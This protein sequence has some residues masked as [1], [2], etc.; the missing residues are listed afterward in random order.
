MR[1]DP[2][3]LEADHEDARPLR[4][5][6]F[7][8]FAYVLLLLVGA[9]GALYGAFRLTQ[10]WV[11]RR[12]LEAARELA[13]GRDPRRAQLLLEQ[14]VQVNPQ[15]LRAQRALAEFLDRA[16]SPDALARWKEVLRLAPGDDEVRLRVAGS[17]LAQADVA[18]AKEALLAVSA[19][20]AASA[21]YHRLAAAL[22]MVEGDAPALEGHLVALA[23]AEPQNPRHRFN[24]AAQRLR[25]SNPQVVAAARGILES[26]ARGDEL[27]I[28]ATLE[29]MA[30]APR[31]WPG[32]ADPL[33][34]L[35]GLIVV[36]DQPLALQRSPTLLPGRADLLNHLFAQPN[37]APADAAHLIDWI[38]SRREGP[39]ALAWL[40]SQRPELA[41]DPA[42]IA[43]TAEA[44][45]QA[46]QW[47]RLRRLLEMGA[48]G[49]APPEVISG[50][51]ALQAR[52]NPRDEARGTWNWLLER[53]QGGRTGLRLLWRL[54]RA[55][56]WDVEADRTLRTIIRLH[57]GENW[58]WE[59]LA[60][61]LLQKRDAAELLQ[62]FER[63]AKAAPQMPR[64]QAERAVLAALLGRLTPEIQEQVATLR[65][66]H[67]DDPGCALASALVLRQRGNLTGALAELQQVRL[68]YRA[69]PRLA[70]YH[71]VML[72]EAGR[73]EESAEL[74]QLTRPAGLL[75]EEQKLREEAET[76]NR[77]TVRLPRLKR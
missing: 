32:A 5:S 27:R 2:D 31:R 47:P 53:T 60:G 7:K 14:A 38:V 43:A 25:S 58:A 26:L 73:P 62:H 63:W 68:P 39:L 8:R 76:R 19:G 18:A 72:S 17:A 30:D 70:L 23:E 67:R 13:A 46:G 33:E 64:V 45:L 59:A 11:E 65:K 61:Q 24:L 37:P 6:A 55:W 29:L 54:A 77:Q 49:P 44:A 34:R 42:V 15:S 50:A 48:W 57:P 36:A 22:A 21:E 20:T 3:R 74:L 75:P 69:E 56:K 41:A 66:S 12:N 9:A 28:R 52:R 16:R 51:F 10:R 4:R 35:A 1:D 71:G 40:D